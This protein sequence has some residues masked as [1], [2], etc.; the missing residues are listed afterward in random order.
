MS[1][2]LVGMFDVSSGLYYLSSGRDAP[3]LIYFARGNL[4]TGTETL[5]G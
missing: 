5:S 4:S 1:T 2:V 3:G